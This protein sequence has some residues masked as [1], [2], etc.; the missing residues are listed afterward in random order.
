MDDCMRTYIY[1]E[2]RGAWGGRCP[3]RRRARRAR[4]VGG[5]GGERVGRGARLSL[6]SL[7][8]RREEGRRKRTERRPALILICSGPEERGQVAYGCA[9]QPSDLKGHSKPRQ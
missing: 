3:S 7:P 6:A 9:V 8:G 2:A 4:G 1:V 5:E